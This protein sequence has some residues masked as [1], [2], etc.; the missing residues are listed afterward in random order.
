M[1]TSQSSTRER[2]LD[3]GTNLL[4]KSGLSGITVGTLAEQTGM[5][6]SG[7][8]AHF[9]SKD[10]IQLCLLDRMIAH[11][12]EA[13]PLYSV[14]SR[15]DLLTVVVAGGGFAG[16]KTVAGIQHFMQSAI[17]S[18]SNLH[19]LQIRVVLVHA[20]AHLLPEL[21][22]QLGRYAEKKLRER[23]IEVLTQRRLSRSQTHV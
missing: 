3:C 9:G 4:S 17:R 2:I 5:S 12:E 23:G 22:E 15:N 8:F 7:P 19:P 21:G 11:L 20:G 10:E 18:Y 1:V 13:D 6:K 16:V 14:S